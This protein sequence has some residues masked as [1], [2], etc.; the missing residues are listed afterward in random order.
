MVNHLNEFYEI[1][2]Q[3]PATDR[4]K[5]NVLRD[6]EMND[7]FSNLAYS[8]LDSL[9]SNAL[10]PQREKLNDTILNLIIGLSKDLEYWKIP[11]NQSYVYFYIN[12]WLKGKNPPPRC[13]AKIQNEL[14]FEEASQNSPFCELLHNCRF[15]FCSGQRKNVYTL[16]C[17]QHNC[18]INECNSER[19][20]G[21]KFCSKHVCPACLITDSKEIRS[22]N[23]FS[24]TIHQCTIERCNKPQIFPY[25]GFC[26]DHVCTECALNKTEKHLP[27]SNSNLCEIHKCCVP[28]C[29]VKRVNTEIEFCS[30]HLC[31]L[32]NSDGFLNGADLT[33]PQSQ[34][35][36]KH[37][38]SIALCLEQKAHP[39]LYCANHSCKE[40]LHSK[41]GIINQ[42]IDKVPR[43]ACKFHK[44]CEFVSPKG[45]R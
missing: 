12:W 8:I 1:Y 42:S 31:R 3:V 29:N 36:N 26:I 21:A 11:R 37:R 13:Q 30:I 38:C 4:R 22:R 44:L 20:K 19:F 17:D 7:I 5:L 45:K 32:C 18:E 33:C 41:S 9:T 28:N 15:P 2:S 24:C 39:S 10:I 43:N 6:D 25:Y 14:C 34:L 40:C 35:C 16:F 23:P 27:R